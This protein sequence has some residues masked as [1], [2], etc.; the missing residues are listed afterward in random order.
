MFRSIYNQSQYILLRGFL[1]TELGLSLAVFSQFCDRSAYL[2]LVFNDY[3][4]ND[5]FEAVVIPI[6]ETK[7]IFST[8]GI[9]LPA[10]IS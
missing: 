4:K 9:P 7:G 5:D 1:G 2:P 10:E 8:F 3:S 6:S